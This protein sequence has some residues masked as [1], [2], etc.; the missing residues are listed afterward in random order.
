VASPIQVAPALL[1][2]MEWAEDSLEGSS[3][4]DLDLEEQLSPLNQ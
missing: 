3:C 4:S 1:R 2:G